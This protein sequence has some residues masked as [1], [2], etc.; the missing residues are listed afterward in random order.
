MKILVMN[1]PNLNML[2]YRDASIYSSRTYEDLCTM[3][4]DKAQKDHD[5]VELFQSNHEGAIIDR[6]HAAITDGTQGIVMNPGAYAHYSYAIRDAL[7]M[8][9]FPVVEVHISDISSRETFR[10]TSVTAPVCD[11]VIIGHGFEGYL[12][13]LD[14]VKE[15]SV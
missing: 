6:I 11:V 1:G 3:I 10:N 7:E 4:T 14:K 2:G 12:E 8:V 5:E 9:S 13:G 15:L